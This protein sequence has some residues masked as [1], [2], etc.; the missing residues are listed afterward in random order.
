MYFNLHEGGCIPTCPVGYFADSNT[1]K[2]C[3]PTCAGCTQT[4]IICNLCAG[5][6]NLFGSGS[7]ITC[8]STCPTKFYST[9]T[10]NGTR[11]C[12]PCSSTCD[13]CRDFS[14]CLSCPNSRLLSSGLC[15]DR[16]D[17]S[18]VQVGDSCKSCSAGCQTCTPLVCVQCASGF[19]LNG[20]CLAECPG[21]FFG[22]P[23]NQQC[24]ACESPCVSCTDTYFCKECGPGFYLYRNTCVRPPCPNQ[25]WF[26]F[27][28][29]VC[30]DVCEGVRF[31]EY[32]NRICYE[33]CPPKTYS[34]VNS[35]TN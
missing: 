15:V 24:T 27:T 12:A 30:S 21:G 2:R 17:S 11:F 33:S 18:S 29:K 35:N 20:S 4:A 31:R 26:N 10:L 8:V 25:G 19:L 13:A 16:C 23:R 32:E 14:Y 34:T 5:S 22:N 1:C 3:S 7:S 28:N 9:Q 6:Q